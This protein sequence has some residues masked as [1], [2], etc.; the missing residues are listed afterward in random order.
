M[1]KAGRILFPAWLL[2]ACCPGSGGEASG[3][4]TLRDPLPV[5]RV[6]P[7]LDSRPSA[8]DREGTALI[9]PA[10]P[11]PVDSVRD[12]RVAFTAGTSGI[13]P[14]GFVLLQVSPWWGWTPPQDEFPDGPGY[15]RAEADFKS[16]K[17]GT[18]VLP[19]N[20]VLVWPMAG[21]VP[22]GGVIS[23][24]YL[25]ARVDRFAE[26]AELFQVFVDADGD[27][28]SAPVEPSPAVEIIAAAPVR[29][30]VNCPSILAPGAPARVEF[31]GLDGAG[32]WGIL[33]GGVYTLAAA[34]DGRAA[35]GSSLEV[36]AGERKAGFDFI[37]GQEGIYFFTVSGPGGLEGG[38][39]ILWCRPGAAA[40]HLYFGDIHG[41]SRVSDGTGTPADYYRYAREVSGLQIAALTDHSDYGTVQVPGKVWEELCRAAQ[42]AYRPGEFVTF[43]AF[44]WTNWVYGHRNVY[45]RDGCGP[46]WRSFDPESDTPQKLWKLLE[47]YEA[48][49][50]AH[51]PGGGPVPTDWSVPP[52][53]KEFFVEIA[54]IHGVSESYGGPDCIYRPVKGAFVFDALARGYRLGLV[55]GGDTHDGHPGQR[56]QG[57]AVTGIMG[58]WAEELTRESVWEAMKARRVYATTG[59]KIILNFRVADAAMGSETEWGSQSG[60]I[61]LAYQVVGCAPLARVEI[62]RSGETV[63]SRPGQGVLERGLLEDPS[64]LSSGGDWYLL[65]VVQ[66]DGNMAWSSPVWVSPP[67]RSPAVPAQSL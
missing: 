12:F 26:A 34:R 48:M 43:A 21:A 50:A 51:H 37:P 52:G 2:W 17:L 63:F 58:V 56:S 35:G 20:R 55:G 1:R 4:A 9:E 16:P 27:G 66:E 19:L 22:P 24:D 11:F 57:A 13:A 14:G 33:P 25:R 8:V 65:K 7:C 39:N 53:E 60:P 38:S 54:S 10:G 44:E 30:Q 61:P 42:E 31:A 32:N 23:F 59:P 47:P 15:V 5:P 45:Y 46:V 28:H 36:K 40:L 29:L 18:A 64:P 3:S 41:H 67:A 6:V 62:V 49:T